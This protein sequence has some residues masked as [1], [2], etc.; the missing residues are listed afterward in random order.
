MHFPLQ[1][2]I[3][4][5]FTVKIKFSD[6]YFSALFKW[7]G[8]KLHFI[9]DGLMSLVC[10]PS[11]AFLFPLSLQPPYDRPPQRRENRRG[12]LSLP[13]PFSA[14]SECNPTKGKLPYESDRSIND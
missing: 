10:G 7:Q 13:S 14:Y 6:G 1:A 4:D 5:C 11:D 9:T 12:F 3:I 2:T 8:Y